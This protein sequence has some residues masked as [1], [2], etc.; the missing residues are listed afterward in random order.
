MHR[1]IYTKVK[2]KN[3]FTTTVE[4]YSR[5]YCDTMFHAAIEDRCMITS[6]CYFITDEGLSPSFRNYREVNYITCVQIVINC[7]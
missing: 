4:T 7:D 1:K 6:I 3:V 5:L 2:I